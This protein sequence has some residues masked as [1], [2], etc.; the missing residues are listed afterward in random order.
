MAS[1]AAIADAMLG[2]GDERQEF[3]FAA[4]SWCTRIRS[5]FAV[6]HGPVLDGVPRMASSCVWV[7]RLVPSNIGVHPDGH[8]SG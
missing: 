6:P 3:S 4:M 1:A 5:P 8:A 7:Y 2:G